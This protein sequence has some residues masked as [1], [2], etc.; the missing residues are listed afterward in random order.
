MVYL[1]A[2]NHEISG[3][4]VDQIFEESRVIKWNK[5]F[6]CVFWLIIPENICEI[7]AARC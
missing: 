4:I 2:Y 1:L 6:F 5:E 7:L 3:K